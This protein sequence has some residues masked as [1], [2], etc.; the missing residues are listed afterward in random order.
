MNASNHA[1]AA[2]TTVPSYCSGWAHA[3]TA[4]QWAQCWK[5]GWNQPTTTA[6]HAGQSAGGQGSTALVVVALIVV[7]VIL[8]MRRSARR[9][10]TA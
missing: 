5:A 4:S 6:V 7:A 10:T 1:V 2:V 8:L 3:I 9:A